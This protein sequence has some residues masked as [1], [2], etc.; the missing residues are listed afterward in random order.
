MTNTGRRGFLKTLG[1]ILGGLTVAGKLKAQETK[2][3]SKYTEKFQKTSIP[4]KA[5]S[6]KELSQFHCSGVYCITGSMPNY[7][8]Y[9]VSGRWD[10]F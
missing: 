1:G 2:F 6:T 10:R 5:L 3:A 7:S 9:Q 8:S 4:S